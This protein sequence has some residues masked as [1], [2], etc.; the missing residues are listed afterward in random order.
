MKM[1]LSAAL[2]FALGACGS[3]AENARQRFDLVEQS[4][5]ATNAELCREARAVAEA[6]LAEGEVERWKDWR[7]IAGPYCLG[8]VPN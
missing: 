4:P 7:A 6:Y 3:L 2:V 5:S 8:L 1:L